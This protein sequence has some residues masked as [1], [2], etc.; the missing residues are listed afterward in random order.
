MN[1]Y[2]EFYFWIGICFPVGTC[3]FY[4]KVIISRGGFLCFRLVLGWR[5]D[6]SKSERER[7]CVGGRVK[8]GNGW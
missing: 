4:L 5:D 2:S 7:E 6:N 1:H 8:D 3:V